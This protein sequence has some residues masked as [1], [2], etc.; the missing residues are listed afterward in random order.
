MAERFF[1]LDKFNTWYDWHSIV[2]AKSI[3]DPEPKTNYVTLDGSNG[4]LDLSEALTGEITYDDRIVTASFW[5]DYGKRN[6]REI[7]LHNITA[8]LHGRKIQIIEPDDPSH[9]LYGRVK[10]KDKT[11]ILPYATYSIEA[12]C[13]P[14][15]YALEESSRTVEIKNF[16]KTVIINNQGVKTLCPVITVDG[17]ITLT[18][19]GI[20]TKLTT[21]TYRVLEIKLF[22]GV[23]VIGVSGKGSVTFTYREATL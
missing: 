20:I 8:A 11:N 9:Y 22:K 21:G 7:L 14:W 5:T 18:Y 23:N 13:E 3:P 6:D 10:V 15:R 17:S 1:T 19:D 16:D 12:Q 2:T 4:T